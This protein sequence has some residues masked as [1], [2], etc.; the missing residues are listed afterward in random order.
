MSA[1][2]LLV[3][4]D[5]AMIGLLVGTVA[6]AAGFETRLTEHPVDFF[7][8]LETWLPSHIVLDLTMPE[9]SGE[10]VIAELVR[11]GCRARLIL[12]SGVDAQRLA[13]TV[14]RAQADGLDLAPALPKPF[15]AQQLREC[16]G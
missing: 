9:M 16:L 10:Q 8:A 1:G 15:R 3:L 11:R 12:S 6:R 2:R 13:D 14:A 5:D 4:D 7:A